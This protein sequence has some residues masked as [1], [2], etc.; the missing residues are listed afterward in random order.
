MISSK[1]ASCKAN[2]CHLIDTWAPMNVWQTSETTFS[3]LDLSMFGSGSL[4]ISYFIDGVAMDRW[5]NYSLPLYV[6]VVTLAKLVTYMVWNVVLASAVHVESP[7]KATVQNN[8]II[9][10]QCKEKFVI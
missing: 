5:W 3:K 10:V 7:P 2:Q 4:V 6:Y 9:T 1:L 8:A